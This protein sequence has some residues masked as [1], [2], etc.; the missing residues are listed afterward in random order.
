MQQT[1]QDWEML[2]VDD[3]SE[4][5]T[6]QVINEAAGLDKRLRV[7]RLSDNSGAATARNLAMQKAKGR[8]IAFLDADDLWLPEKMDRQLAFMR[9]KNAAFSFTSYKM[10]TETGELLA[11]R[12]EVPASIDYPGLLK[13]TIIGCLTVMLDSKITG[14]L[15]M[16]DLRS[17]QDY[18]LWFRLLRDGLVAYGLDED[19]ARYRL[20]PG[21]L[22]RN[23]LNAARRMW[24]IYRVYEGLSLPYSV[25]CFANYSWNAVRKGM[26]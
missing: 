15:K 11:G 25:W 8:Y 14:P 18:T 1:F 21:S 24:K 19:L 26:G 23:K 16:E 13:N 6:W 3:A 9:S 5:S 10:M 4:D 12:V 22:S 17:G 20:V 2:I 7:F